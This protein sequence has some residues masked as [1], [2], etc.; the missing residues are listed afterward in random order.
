MISNLALMR[1]IKEG[2]LV[3]LPAN[4]TLVQKHID[5]SVL[6]HTTTDK[7]NHVVLIRKRA[8]QTHDGSHPCEVLY[9]AERWLVSNAD[10]YTL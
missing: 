1:N 5:G 6:R 7:P 10:L 8:N 9:N 3:Y 4:V 2:D